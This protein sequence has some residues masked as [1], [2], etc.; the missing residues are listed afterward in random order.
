MHPKL[1]LA[2]R[3]PFR[4]ALLA[5]LHLAFDVEPADLDESRLAGEPARDMAA[6]LAA[7]KARAVAKQHATGAARQPTLLI[8]SDQ[9]VE[10]DDKVLGK[11]GNRDN[12]VRQL[13]RLSGRVVDFH[14]GLTVRS[15]PDGRERH[16]LETVRVRFRALDQRAIDA[17]LDKEQPYRSAGSFQAE[18]YGVTLV[19]AIDSADPTALIGLPL[20]PLGRLLRDAGLRLP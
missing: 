2:S 14:T 3:S 4:R 6:R 17:Y 20:I 18:G 15:E 1:I 19:E 12:A 8:G 16:A 11:P 13:R 5:R 9:T 7:A 10:L